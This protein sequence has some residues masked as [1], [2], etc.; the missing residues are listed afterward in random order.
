MR[1]PFT[2]K[3]PEDWTP[4]QA[5]AVFEILNELTDTLWSR[6]DLAIIELLANDRYPGDTSQLDLFDRDDPQPF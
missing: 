3:L 4:E 1:V 2:L 6:Y 5:L